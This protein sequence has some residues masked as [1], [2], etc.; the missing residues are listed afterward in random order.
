[1]NGV[2]VGW[3]LQALHST[4]DITIDLKYEDYMFYVDFL[5]C[6]ARNFRLAGVEPIFVFAGERTIDVSNMLC[7]TYI[8]NAL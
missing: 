3:I 8:V 5:I 1:M 2:V 4:L 6:R 7:S